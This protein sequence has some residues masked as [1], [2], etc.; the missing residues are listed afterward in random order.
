M[1]DEMKTTRISGWPYVRASLLARHRLAREQHR[2]FLSC[3]VTGDEKWCLGVFM[4][5]QMEKKGIVDAEEEKNISEMF[6]FLHLASISSDHG[7][8]HYLQMTKLQYVN[9]SS[10]F[11]L[12]IK[13]HHHHQCSAQGQVLHYKCRHQGCNSAQRQVFHSKLRN[14]GCSF[15]RKLIGAVAS[16]CFSN[17]ILSLGSEQTLKDLKD[18]RGTNEEV[19]TVDLA[20]WVLRT[21]PKFATGVKHQFHQDF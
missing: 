16:R 9:S 7:S 8:T 11:K 1:N 6:Q 18:P 19:M 10:T 2:P 17:P 4:L 20:N 14:Q 5:T 13:N 3:I 15:T 12:Q 21:S